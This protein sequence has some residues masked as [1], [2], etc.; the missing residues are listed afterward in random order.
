MTNRG[1]A[2]FLALGL[3]WGMPYLLIRIAVAS[4]DPL[5][6]AFGR[7]LI[8]S[9][10]LLPVALNRNALVPVLRHWRWIIVFTLVEI[11][12]PWL[13]IGHSET[14]LNSSTT[15][16][17]IAMVPLLAA[18]I[19]GWFGHERFDSRRILGLALGFAGV[20]ALVGLDVHLS[21]LAAALALALASLGYAVGPIILHRQ[22]KDAPTLG[23]VTSSVIVAARPALPFVI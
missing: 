1:W 6:V 4:I 13:L 18:L 11:S 8:G 5:V 12:A 9:L 20:A 21:D 16:L 7:T 2:L 19:V 3:I 14:P 15:A 17:L 23:V 10:I 22:L